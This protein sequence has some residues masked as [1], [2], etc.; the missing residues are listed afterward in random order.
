MDI[1]ILF[2]S[3]PNAPRNVSENQRHV[4]FCHKEGRKPYSNLLKDQL[5]KRKG[6]CRGEKH[7]S[8]NFSSSFTG[9]NFFLSQFC[10]SANLSTDVGVT[11]TI[12]R[13]YHLPTHILTTK[14]T[15]LSLK[16]E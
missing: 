7:V 5:L 6:F 13:P 14:T 4:E 2:K 15:N 12:L 3:L 16:T 11:L 8:K 1:I 10:R 9:L